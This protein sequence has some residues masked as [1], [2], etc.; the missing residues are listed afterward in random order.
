MHSNTDTS[1]RNQITS[2]LTNMSLFSN[3]EANVMLDTEPQHLKY[4][5]VLYTQ[6]DKT[7]VTDILDICVNTIEKH[8]I[9]N[10]K[11]CK[12]IKDTLDKKYTPH[13]NI[14]IGS[15][16]SCEITYESKFILYFYFGI[17]TAVLLW[18]CNYK[19]Y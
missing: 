2:S 5:L 1:K 12:I 7:D 9:D 6:L 3:T 15:H 4:P 16:H 13:W 10:E 18:K 14:V 8:G 17:D 19:Y 11:C